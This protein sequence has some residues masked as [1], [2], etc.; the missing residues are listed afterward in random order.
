MNVWDNFHKFYQW[1]FDIICTR[2]KQDVQYWK[3]MAKRYGD[4]ILE[5]GCGAGR[6]TIPLAEEG[7]DITA[8]DYSEVMIDELKSKS[9]LFTKLKPVLGDMTDFKF[10]KKFKF[11]F[12]SYSSF[13]LLLTRAQ[14]EK[15][16]KLIY[17]HLEDDGILG[18]D[19]AACVC[20]GDD[21]QIDEP[22][23]TAQFPE[24]NSQ[25]T[26]YSS[27]KTDRLNMIRYWSDEYI[28]Y[29]KNGSQSSYLNKIALRECSP[30][31]MHYILQ[32][33]GFKL[34]HSYGDFNLGILDKNSFNALYIA[35]KIKKP[36]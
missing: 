26:M 8:L 28:Q 31:Y 20:E 17:E 11:I 23:Y 33:F 10:D 27:Y 9:A 14:Q 7:Y 24:N 3:L 6:I 15:C 12:I 25:V 29:L 30:D 34:E 22:L 4:P 1:E 5:L 19:I 18:F 21:E 16:L 32:N 2:Q 13:Q 36:R 35:R